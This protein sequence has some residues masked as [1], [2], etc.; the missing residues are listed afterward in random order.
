M[1][2]AGT[3]PQLEDRHCSARG[4]DNP[5]RR[6]LAPPF[7]EL[8]RLDVRPGH[9]VADLGASVGYFD[10]E[11]LRR[12][13]PSGHL[14]A[15]DIDRDNLAIARARLGERANLT[16]AIASAASV[17]AIETE[18]VDRV[19]LSL[20]LCCMVDKAGALREAHRILRPGGLALVTYPRRYLPF[21]PGARRRK[22]LRVTPRRWSE[23][24]DPSAWET[25]PVDR[26]FWIERHLLR[27]RST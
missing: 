25:L 5:I 11:I 4:L 6:R 16:I 27:R 19:L 22:S 18:S 20:V 21:L 15:V 24:Y 26:S 13:G 8:D 23:L 1:V 17:G 7:R 9:V 12:I 14:F 2:A 3:L 10:G